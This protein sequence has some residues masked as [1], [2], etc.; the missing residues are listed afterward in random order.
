[1]RPKTTNVAAILCLLAWMRHGKRT[2]RSGVHARLR[3]NPQLHEL[4]LDDARLHRSVVR[5]GREA[6]RA[7]RRHAQNAGAAHR[8]RRRGPSMGRCR[9][10]RTRKSPRIRRS[11]SRAGFCRCAERQASHWRRNS[12]STASPIYAHMGS[13]SA[14]VTSRDNACMSCVEC[15]RSTSSQ[16][17][18][19]SAYASLF[20]NC[21]TGTHTLR[22]QPRVVLERRRIDGCHARTLACR[23]RRHR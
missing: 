21:V 22:D 12:S 14:V 19:I 4:S 7:R 16:R 8:R 1:M 11:R 18:A 15:S 3:S 17:A 10:P 5:Q 13:S 23:A 9:C 20:R 2:R 6:I